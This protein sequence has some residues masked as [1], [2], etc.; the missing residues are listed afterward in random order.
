MCDRR[1]WRCYISDTLLGEIS[2]CLC[3]KSLLCSTEP[4]LMGIS[5]SYSY[6]M[7]KIGCEISASKSQTIRIAGSYL[8]HFGMRNFV[9]SEEIAGILP[10]FTEE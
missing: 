10:N 3:A 8:L 5:F 9:F 1:Y 7:Y 2:I 4:P 6:C